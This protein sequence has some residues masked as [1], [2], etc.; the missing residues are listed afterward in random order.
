MSDSSA[1]HEAVQQEE[2]LEGQDEHVEEV[3]SEPVVDDEVEEEGT[4]HGEEA[5]DDAADE[6]KPVEDDDESSPAA[7]EENAGDSHSDM[8]DSDRE[9]GEKEDVDGQED[10]DEKSEAMST[11]TGADGE[12]KDKE[13]EDDD[14]PKEEG[15]DEVDGEKLEGEEE[16][17]ETVEGETPVAEEVPAVPQVPARKLT[18]KE[19]KLER[20]KL[21][22]NAKKQVADKQLKVKDADRDKNWCKTWKKR[23]GAIVHANTFYEDGSSDDVR[24]KGKG[25]EVESGDLKG[26][27]TVLGFDSVLAS[28]AAHVVVAQLNSWCSHEGSN[29]LNAYYNHFFKYYWEW[30]NEVAYPQRKRERKDRRKFQN[31]KKKHD[32]VAAKKDKKESQQAIK[33]AKKGIVRKP[34]EEQPTTPEVV[35]PEQPV[36]ETANAEGEK[37]AEDAKDKKAKKGKGKLNLDVEFGTIEDNRTEQQLT[38]LLLFQLVNGSCSDLRNCKGILWLLYSKSRRDFYSGD[39]RRMRNIGKWV[40]RQSQDIFNLMYF[41]YRVALRNEETFHWDDMND[42]CCSKRF[43]KKILK[44]FDEDEK[45]YTPLK[46]EAQTAEADAASSSGGEEKDELSATEEAKDEPQSVTIELGEGAEKKEGDADLDGDKTDRDVVDDKSEA[47]DIEGEPVDEDDN[48]SETGE[49]AEDEDKP[50][51][52]VLD[53]EHAEVAEERA[54]EEDAEHVETED[55]ASGDEATDDTAVNAEGDGEDKTSDDHSDVE[56]G[57]SDSESESEE[58]ET[59]EP[60]EEESSKPAEDVVIDMDGKEEKLE[61]AGEEADKEAPAADEE[62]KPEEETKDEGVFEEVKLDGEED[63]KLP[64]DAEKEAAKED[65]SS[66]GSTAE[67]EKKKK[68]SRKEKKKMHIDPSRPFLSIFFGGCQYDLTRKFV[69]AELGEHINLR[70]LPFKTKQE[71]VLT[72]DEKQKVVDFMTKVGLYPIYTKPE[73][74]LMKQEAKR[75]AKD[76]KRNAK[77]AKKEQAKAAKEAKKKG[78]NPDAQDVEEAEGSTSTAVVEEKQKMSEKELDD[79]I[80]KLQDLLEEERKKFCNQWKTY[81]EVSGG[82]FGWKGYLSIYALN[83][84]LVFYMLFLGGLVIGWMVMDVLADKSNYMQVAMMLGGGIGFGLGMFAGVYMPIYLWYKWKSN[85]HGLF[86]PS[87]GFSS[88]YNRGLGFQ[89]TSFG[90]RCVVFL[91]LLLI[92]VS[93]AV[94]CRYFFY[95]GIYKALDDLLPGFMDRSYPAMAAI[96]AVLAAL[97]IPQ[98]IFFAVISQSFY[99]F[100]VSLGALFWGLVVK[101]SFR[102]RTWDDVKRLYNNGKLK[103]NFRAKVVPMIDESKVDMAFAKMWN[104]IIENCYEEFLCTRDFADKEKFTIV[105]T[106]Q[107]VGYLDGTITATPSFQKPSDPEMQSRITRYCN[108]VMRK[109]PAP[110]PIKRLQ[111]LQVIVPVGPSEEL[112]YSWAYLT[113]LH[114]TNTTFLGYMIR[115][116]PKRWQ[117]FRDQPHVSEEQRK[118]IDKISRAVFSV[119]TI[120]E[121]NDA[122]LKLKIRQWASLHFQALYRTV[123]G[124]MHTPRAFKILLRI[125]NPDM[126]VEEVKKILTQKFSCVVALQGMDSYIKASDNDVESQ[127]KAKSAR[128]LQQAFPR[129]DVAWAREDIVTDETGQQKAN[130]F[131]ILEKGT[132]PHYLSDKATTLEWP[133]CGPIGNYATGQGKPSNSNFLSAYMDGEITQ[134]LDVNQA[135]NIGDAFMIPNVLGNFNSDEKL[136]S[137]GVANYIPTQS[138]GLAAWA[139]GFT[140]RMFTSLTQKALG[141]LDLRL[142]YGHSDFLRTSY[143]MT[144]TGLSKL[145]YVPEDVVGGLDMLFKGFKNIHI[146]YYET[147]KSRDVC[148]FTTTQFVRK[149]AMGSPQMSQSRFYHRLRKS[150]PWLAQPIFYYS[151][152][153]F[154]YHFKLMVLSLLLLFFLQPFILVFADVVDVSGMSSAYVAATTVFIWHIG[155]IFMIPALFLLMSEEGILE[156]LFTFI[157]YLIPMAVFF[158]FHIPNYSYAF[159]KGIIAN[160]VYMPSGR[161]HGLSHKSF[162]ETFYDFW[163][164]HIP[165]STLIL[166]F[167]FVSFCISGSWLYLFFMPLLLSLIWFWGPFLFNRGAVPLDVDYNTWI[168]ILND[169]VETVDHFKTSTRNNAYYTWPFLRCF[170]RKKQKLLTYNQ[171]KKL[172][173]KMARKDRKMARKNAKKG[174]PLAL[175]MNAAGAFPITTPEGETLIAQKVPDPPAKQHRSCCTRMGRCLCFPCIKFVAFFRWIK[176][177]MYWFNWRLV[178]LVVLVLWYSLRFLGFILSGVQIIFSKKLDYTSN[179]HNTVMSLQQQLE[180]GKFVVSGTGGGGG[181]GTFFDMGKG[182]GVPGGSYSMGNGGGFTLSG[183]SAEQL[184]MFR[185]AIDAYS[186]G[187]FGPRQ[188]AA[189]PL[190]NKPF[191]SMGS[192]FGSSSAGSSSAP[193]PSEW[194]TSESLAPD[195]PP[196]PPT[197]LFGASGL[198]SD[199]LAN[200]CAVM[201]PAQQIKMRMAKSNN[202]AIERN[203]PQITATLMK[204]ASVCQSGFAM[205]NPAAVMDLQRT[206]KDTV[207]RENLEIWMETVEDKTTAEYQCIQQCLPLLSP[208]EV[209]A[210]VLRMAND[211]VAPMDALRMR[212]A[213]DSSKVQIEKIVAKQCKAF[214]KYNTSLVKYLVE[215]QHDYRLAQESN[216]APGGLVMVVRQV[217]RSW[218]SLVIKIMSCAMADLDSLSRVRQLYSEGQAA[219]Q[220]IIAIASRNARVK[221]W[222]MCIHSNFQTTEQIDKDSGFWTVREAQEEHYGYP[223]LE[224]LNHADPGFQQSVIQSMKNYMASDMSQW[225][226]ELSEKAVGGMESRKLQVATAQG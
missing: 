123:S 211:C 194:S 85:Q 216:L 37:P 135:S 58:G 28:H 49:A 60:V 138:W 118:D 145:P 183:L 192:S 8:A 163:K 186:G 170:L 11:A 54:E 154:F 55:E 187:G 174:T 105:K 197:T 7:D 148:S 61:E 31:Q 96:V 201:T 168:S 158:S 51:E 21:I 110:T 104:A 208:L 115:K 124:A 176:A 119:N 45:Q 181:G 226:E 173:A 68:L 169:D 129:L 44:Y 32:K 14:V 116:W 56:G 41:H 200:A 139:A 53:S 225:V 218:A 102:V 100:W 157:K 149:I 2:R 36:D 171:L 34:E 87:A 24:G 177:L 161:G 128:Y 39:L 50:A 151:T 97:I 66:S 29:G 101:K 77:L 146:D 16:A 113:T 215:N 155:M 15:D 156:G 127:E 93:T 189:F 152:V 6:Q 223:F 106:S 140:E 89:R 141:L 137:V 133:L 195:A 207:E 64:E 22:E 121:I 19:K 117:N 62:V 81:F 23:M 18:R 72:L 83:P 132:H 5:S 47:G 120:P 153:G 144:S 112:F 179:L 99:T 75:K 214:A 65:A 108:Y 175:E 213:E 167:G 92:F 91:L 109:A 205:N 79:I 74:K 69:T 224:E 196:P 136:G 180:S 166:V 30:Q 191:P 63:E 78:E 88:S 125:Q 164:S 38:D 111:R 33:D 73:E 206:V 131:A 42:L 126:P 212:L 43:V 10:V 13:L 70:I 80:H 107:D 26:K 159:H 184:E 59:G 27:K 204:V 90:S 150:L 134:S 143:V 219:S 1:H 52:E 3:Q 17:A 142:N 20:K 217:A 4:E 46:E 25:K 209:A 182:D 147:G 193:P 222:F 35:D 178:V 203:L 185:K 210:N 71:S 82:R 40:L 122:E 162:V 221:E 130:W 114:T 86:K 188:P 199:A 48:K 94:T 76:D 165:L 172:E 84:I 198:A 160:A 220:H 103:T 67:A 98:V 57:A 95:Q 12:G 190:S 202:A 9:T